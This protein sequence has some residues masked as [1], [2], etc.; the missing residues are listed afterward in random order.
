MWR[1][2]GR[3]KGGEQ[4][5]EKAGGIVSGKE[6]DMSIALEEGREGK[7]RKNEAGKRKREQKIKR[8]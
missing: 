3:K 6:G 7:R 4:E 8:G 1:K 2:E 5:E